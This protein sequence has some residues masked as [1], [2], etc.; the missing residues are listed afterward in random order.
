M[1]NQEMLNGMHEH[2][3]K[4][5]AVLLKQGRDKN[6]AWLKGAKHALAMWR[7][8]LVS[9]GEYLLSHPERGEDPTEKVVETLYNDETSQ[10]EEETL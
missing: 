6:N 8:S 7:E 4:A 10:P 5:T 1:T 2:L 3:E 9:V